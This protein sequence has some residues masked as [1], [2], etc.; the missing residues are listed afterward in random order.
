MTTQTPMRAIDPHASARRPQHAGGEA[1]PSLHGRITAG[2]S[3]PL[4]GP[5]LASPGAVQ[6]VRH[7]P[8]NFLRA[9]NIARPPAQANG[10]RHGRRPE[11]CGRA[12]P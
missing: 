1:S 7:L 4:P 2:A 10:S 6:P 5:R 12:G 11:P 8:G 9:P 3:T